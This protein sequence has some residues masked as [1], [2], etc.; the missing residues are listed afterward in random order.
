MPDIYGSVDTIRI[1]QAHHCSSNSGS[2]GET[3]V[4]SGTTELTLP[5]DVYNNLGNQL[6]SNSIFAWNFPTIF[7][8]DDCYTPT[9]GLS[10]DQ[11]NTQLPQLTITLGSGATLYLDP[12]GSYLRPIVPSDL[13]SICYVLGIA[14]TSNANT[15]LG[16]AVMNQYTTIFDRANQRIGFAPTQNCGSSNQV[17]SAAGVW[18]VTA[19][20]SCTNCQQQRTIYCQWPNGTIANSTEPCQLLGVPPT[21]AYCCAV[22]N[23]FPYNSSWGFKATLIAVFVGLPLVLVVGFLIYRCKRRQN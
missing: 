8:G 15:I 9:D 21:S 14:P 4:D 7:S 22:N 18:K 13:S 12:V 10:P 23:P 17:P 16:W 5:T 1:I 11:L 2:F 20:G 19:T 3:I 6:L